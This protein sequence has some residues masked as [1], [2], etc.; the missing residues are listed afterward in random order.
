MA[1]VRIRIQIV[2]LAVA[3]VAGVGLWSAPARAATCQPGVGVTVVIDPTGVPGGGSKGVDTSCVSTNGSQN[4]RALFRSAGV[5]MQDTSRF[6]GLVCLVNGLPS[7]TPGCVMAPPGNAYWGLF[8]STGLDGKWIYSSIGVDGL[9]VPDGGSISWT[10]QGGSK[11]HPRVSPPMSSSGSPEQGTG[12]TAPNKPQKSKKPGKSGSTQQGSASPTPTS[13]ATVTPTR[14]V[15]PPVESATP[16]GQA[17]QLDSGTPTAEA[18]TAPRVN[19]KLD[20]PEVE[21]SGLPVWIPVTVLVALSAAIG[22]AMIV[23]RRRG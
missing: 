13:S 5:S 4:A 10:W 16:T 9:K 20:G 2:S 19:S 8:W 15:S 6:P 3:I 1:M 14:S 11:V 22:A 17:S 12:G 18:D 23:R 21:S 7:P